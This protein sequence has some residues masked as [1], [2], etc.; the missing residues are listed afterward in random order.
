MG[1]VHDSG[2][3]FSADRSFCRPRIDP[4]GPE[5]FVSLGPMGLQVPFFEGLHPFFRAMYGYWGKVSGPLAFEPLRFG[6]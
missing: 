5:V 3:F 6:L 2:R 1:C 4:F